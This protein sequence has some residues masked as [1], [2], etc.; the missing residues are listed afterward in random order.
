VRLAL[1]ATLLLGGCAHGLIAP[2]PDVPEGTGATVVIIYY[3]E[4][5]TSTGNVE[6]GV[7]VKVTVDGRETLGIASGEYVVLPLPAGER[8]IGVKCGAIEDTILL[9]L[10]AGTTSYLRI[11]PGGV[12]APTSE[13]SA[14]NLGRSR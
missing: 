5:T 3:S 13:S 11:A 9:R 12:N 6:G 1:L 2:L 8:V 14:G 4:W 7:P 10:A